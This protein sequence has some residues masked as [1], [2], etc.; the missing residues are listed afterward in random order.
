LAL[1]SEGQDFSLKAKAKTFMRPRGQQD[2]KEGREGK[3]G[4]N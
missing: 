1:A 4:D 3:G 2:W